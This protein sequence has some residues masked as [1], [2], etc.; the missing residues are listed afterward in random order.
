VAVEGY[1]PIEVAEPF[2]GHRSLLQAG[3]TVFLQPDPAR[4]NL[5]TADMSASLMGG[6]EP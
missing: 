4:V 6:G 3:D 2:A 5:F 1:P